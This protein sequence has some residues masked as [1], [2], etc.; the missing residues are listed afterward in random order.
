KGTEQVRISEHFGPG[1]DVVRDDAITR[2]CERLR[3]ACRTREAIENSLRIY[4]LSEQKNVRQQ[5]QFRAR[6]LDAFG[7]GSGHDDDIVA[8]TSVPAN[9]HGTSKRTH[10]ETQD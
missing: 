1:G 2:L 5:L 8:P 9:T 7:W 3:D 6:V 10:N 4:F